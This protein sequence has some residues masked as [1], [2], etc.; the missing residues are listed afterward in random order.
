MRITMS[1]KNTIAVFK[2]THKK[3]AKQPDYNAVVTIDGTERKFAL[4]NSKSKNGLS[5]LGGVESKP[6]QKNGDRQQSRQ[7]E[8]DFPF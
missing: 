8:E 4:W 3:E 1:D 5:Y 7:E 6:Q 2:N